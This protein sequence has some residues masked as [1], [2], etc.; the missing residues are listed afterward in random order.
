MKYIFI[1]VVMSIL[2]SCNIHEDKYFEFL[3]GEWQIT[4]FY[5]KKENIMLTKDY[6]LLGFEKNNQLWFTRIDDT[7]DFTSS[8]YVLLKKSNTLKIDIKNCED[9]RFN[10]N[11]NFSIDTIQYTGEQYLI[12]ITLNSGNTLIQAIRPKIKY[13]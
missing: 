12:Q 1:N 7:K 6:S 8:D 2:F 10:D 4:K 3:K 9:S 5:Y 11:Y 13:Q